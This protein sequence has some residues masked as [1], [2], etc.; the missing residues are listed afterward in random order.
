MPKI[1]LTVA[2]QLGQEEARNRITSL[3]ADSRTRFAGK[4][5]NVAETWNGYVDAFSFEAMG[6]SVTGKLEVQPGQVL[7]EMH[8]PWAAYP[9][10]A[11]IENEILTHARQLLA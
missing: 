2:H 3:M 7:V 11:R 10:K 5:S 9:F 1:E 6:F 8:L 4:I